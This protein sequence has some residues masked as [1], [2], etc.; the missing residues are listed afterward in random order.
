MEKNILE[1]RDNF[2][3]KLYEL[4]IGKIKLQEMKSKA[5]AF[6]LGILFVFPMLML[7]IVLALLVEE[8]ITCIVAML[9]GYAT[10]NGAWQHYKKCWKS[11]LGGVRT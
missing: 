9:I 10:P 7:F 3:L 8:P 1:K 5:L 6:F 11:L 4:T 2:T